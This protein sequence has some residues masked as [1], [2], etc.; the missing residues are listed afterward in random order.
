[1]KKNK[2]NMKK[3]LSYILRLV[4][5]VL[6]LASCE[7]KFY[8]EEQYRKEIYIVSDGSHIF[9]Q[10]YTFG[11]E[12]EGWLS[13]YAA[14]TTPIERD[15]LVE[16]EYWPELLRRYNRTIWGESYASY[17]QELDAT[18][19]TIDDYTLTLSKD[20]P[21]PYTMFPIRVNVSSINPDDICFIPLRIKS[22]SDYMISED[23]RE[24]LFRIYVKNDYAT[25]KS[26]T[27]YTMNGTEQMCKETDG[28]F[29]PTGEPSTINATKPIVPV[30]EQS[31]RILPGTTYST[32][33]LIISQ[34]GVR[35]T[36]H[37]DELVDVPVLVDG[38]PTGEMLKRQLVTL[39][40]WE[41]TSRSVVVVPVEDQPSYYDPT[42]KTFTLNYRYKQ[43]TEVNW[44]FM[45]E[46]MAPL[47][48]T[49]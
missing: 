44:H 1:M 12:S 35:V 42:A 8:D 14:G 25:T 27:Y 5:L 39:N 10:E 40:T 45:H 2:N 16:L 36:V 33:A 26:T 47:N 31:V 17:A 4:S 29:T 3:T 18:C 19:Y 41:E 20:N 32:A 30:G 38:V 49:D 24:V 28:T 34:K 43:P 6:L 23:K 7:A 21:K 15:V 11:E 46:V 48:I 22:V 9:G 37:P 13:I